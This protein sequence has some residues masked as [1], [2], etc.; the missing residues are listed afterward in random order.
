MI[1]LLVGTQHYSMSYLEKSMKKLQI[2]KDANE[3][4][5]ARVV[6]SQQAVD[7]I[8]ALKSS[9][10]KESELFKVTQKLQATKHKENTIRG[11]MS[12]F[13]IS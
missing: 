6:N 13:E 5:M 8:N 11:G 1:L 4:P 10:A 12:S 9:G 3:N 7:I 2:L